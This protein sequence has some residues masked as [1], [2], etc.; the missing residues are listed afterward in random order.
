M[1][2][3]PNPFGWS[4]GLIRILGFILSYGHIKIKRKS[5]PPAPGTEA[6]IP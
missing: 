6:E 2:Y 1:S 5:G 3:S 4:E